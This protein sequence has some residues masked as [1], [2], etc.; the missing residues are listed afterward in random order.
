M[1]ALGPQHPALSEVL[2]AQALQEYP[3]F[4]HRIFGCGNT[5]Q[6]GNRTTPLTGNREEKALMGA[7]FLL[8]WT[9]Q[10]VFCRCLGAACKGQ[11]AQG[12][13]GSQGCS[14]VFQLHLAVL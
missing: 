9:S 12:Q 10:Y 13:G 6:T 8:H 4:F 7:G 11:P 14:V 5:L 1:G 3:V 2:G